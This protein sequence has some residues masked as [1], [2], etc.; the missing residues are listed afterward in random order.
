MKYIS[1]LLLLPEICFAN[2]QKEASMI[3]PIIFKDYPLQRFV[4]DYA[5]VSE[6]TIISESE[7]LKRS[8]RKVNLVINSKINIQDFS[9]MFFTILE[10]N[11]F[12]AIQEGSFV[13][14]INTRDIRY[15]PTKLYESKE[16]P[17]T[18]EYIFVVHQLK[19]P[20]AGEITRNM[21]PFLS[22]YGRIID[23]NDSHSIAVQDRG[24]N[25][26]RLIDLMNNLDNPKSIDRLK[27]NIKLGKKKRSK[28]ES[29]EDLELKILKLQKAK[30]EKELG[31]DDSHPSKRRR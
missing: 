22:R 31:Y 20:L 30:L 13:R 25:I 26:E 27:K 14:I 9:K 11:G 15:S 5:Q 10:S 24:K 4:S 7:T 1:L 3:L 17:K 2:I 28:E 21:R 8:K 12:T 19:N 16:F 29:K 23:F 6:K 18:D